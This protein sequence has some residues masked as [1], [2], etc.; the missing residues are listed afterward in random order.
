MTTDT[1]TQAQANHLAALLDCVQQGQPI[2]IVLNGDFER[3]V[4]GVARHFVKSPDDYAF[5]GQ[6]TDVRDAYVRVSATFDHAYPVREL[7]AG[8]A[9]ETVFLNTRP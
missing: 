1:L 6:D 4:V 9:N 5:I 2:T 8:I 3:P 7:L